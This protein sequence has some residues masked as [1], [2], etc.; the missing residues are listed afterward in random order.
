MI[1]WYAI[2]DN[3]INRDTEKCI[4]VINKLISDGKDIILIN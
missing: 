4:R 1:A 3:I 2:V